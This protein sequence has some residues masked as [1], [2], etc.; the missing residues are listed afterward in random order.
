MVY[1]QEQKRN[2]GT[3][4]QLYSITLLHALT[5]KTNLQGNIKVFTSRKFFGSYYHSVTE[6]YP[7]EYRLFSGR[8]SNI[9]KEESIFNRMKIF[10]NLASNHHSENIYYCQ[11]IRENLS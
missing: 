4:L 8:T 9:E 3:I 1:Y 5:I 11:C 7:F 10:I 2:S 6:H